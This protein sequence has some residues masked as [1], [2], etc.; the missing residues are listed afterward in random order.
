MSQ[1]NDTDDDAIT[2]QFELYIEKSR[3][4]H[5][6]SHRARTAVKDLKSR[7]EELRDLVEDMDDGDLA[8]QMHTILDRI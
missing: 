4:G 6:D 1:P 8:E 3:S 2:R 5:V 7:R